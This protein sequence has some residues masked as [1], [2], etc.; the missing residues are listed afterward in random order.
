MSRRDPSR[1]PPGGARC[2]RSFK[3]HHFPHYQKDRVAGWG[4][5]A[6]WGPALTKLHGPYSAG[7]A[8]VGD[9][10]RSV[11]PSILPHCTQQDYIDRL[12]HLCPLTHMEVDHLPRA[13]VNT[14]VRL[15]LQRPNIRE[16]CQTRRRRT[17]RAL[18]HEV[19]GA[20]T[21]SLKPAASN[22]LTRCTKSATTPVAPASLFCCQR[23]S[24]RPRA[25][26]HA[27][28]G[29]GGSGRGGL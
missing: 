24:Y 21:T 15:S 2:T 22:R 17:G 13:S 25:R 4:F 5:L 7:S 12:P 28:Q 16:W 19:A 18:Y 14:C 1:A 20:A 29:P 26:T 6:S 11:P 3:N 8:A 9:L 10:S 27:V 23:L